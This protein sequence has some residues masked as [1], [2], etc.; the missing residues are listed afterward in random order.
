MQGF[1][2]RIY[3]YKKLF[4]VQRTFI[5][6]ALEHQTRDKNYHEIYI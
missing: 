5:L 1:I 2:T 4:K 6:K 3:I